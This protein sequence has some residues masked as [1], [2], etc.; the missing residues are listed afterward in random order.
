MNSADTPPI[1]D[2]PD[3]YVRLMRAQRRVSPEEQDEMARDQHREST[4][5]RIR[6]R[7]PKAY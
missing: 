6:R 5:N 4:G 7:L 2:L 1:D 3:A